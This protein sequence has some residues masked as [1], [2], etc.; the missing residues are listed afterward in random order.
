M[1]NNGLNA[2]IQPEAF[3]GFPNNLILFGYFNASSVEPV[4]EK[5]GL[6]MDFGD[7]L[8]GSEIARFM[9]EKGWFPVINR[10]EVVGSN[11]TDEIELEA[12]KDRVKTRRRRVV[13]PKK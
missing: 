4:P 1:K 5:A 12:L 8:T 9:N 10:A 7:G 13:L 2:L 11:E 3:A 6:T